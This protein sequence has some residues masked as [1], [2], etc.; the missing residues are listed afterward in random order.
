M[1]TNAELWERRQAAVPRGIAS[2]CPIFPERAENSEIWDV[3]GKRYIDF[4][5]GIAVLN[6]GHRHPRVQERV[7]TQVEKFSHTSFQVMPYTPYIEL[8]ERLNGLAPGPGPWKSIFLTTGAEAVENAVKIAR[9]HTGRSDVIAF[10]G[11]FHGRTLLTMTMTGKVVPYKKGFGPFPGEVHHAPYPMEYRGIAPATSLRCIQELFK[12]AVD[13]EQVAAIV[14]EPVL[15]E[16]GFYAAPADFLRDL[17]SLCD[18]HGI[19][20]VSDEV[21]SGFARTGRFFAIEHAGVV[22]DLITVAKS[23]AGGYPLSGVIGKAEVMDAPHPG[24]LGGTYGGNPV[25]CAAALGVLDAIEQD[26]LLARA[27]SMGERIQGRLG[28]MA[29]KFDVIGDVRTLGAMNAFELVKDRVTLEPD[30]DRT[31]RLRAR[32]LDHGLV[33]LACGYYSNVIRILVPLTANDAIVDEGLELI[34][35]SLSDT[36][37]AR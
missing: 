13:P 9:Y 33:L 3:E 36:Q 24:G 10:S 4:A 19:M 28:D 23:L 25:A 34:E 37:E 18:K 17:R 15:G 14:L 11:G 27:V 5:G 30:P 6:T 35:R 20:L 26:G 2:A 31:A 16:G 12:T 21:Q 8:A 32:A 7:R 22:P 1:S 29:G